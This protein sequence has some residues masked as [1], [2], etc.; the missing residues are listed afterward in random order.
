MKEIYM[1]VS[2]VEFGNNEVECTFTQQIDD[3]PLEWES[4][5]L[6]KALRMQWELVLAGGVRNVRVSRLDRHIVYRDIYIFLPN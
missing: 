4:I 6:E 5:P 1:N 3:E 2:I